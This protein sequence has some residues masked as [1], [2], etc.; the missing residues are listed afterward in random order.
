MRW[1]VVAPLVFS[2]FGCGG[3]LAEG[4]ADFRQAQYPAAKQAFAALEV[5]MRSGDDATRAEYA[6]YRGLTFAALGDLSRAVLWLREA[7]ALEDARGGALRAADA[8]RL[9]VA[10]EANEIP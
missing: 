8:R 9:A 6:L 2:L 10:L 4:E 1:P 5:E 3:A 7:K